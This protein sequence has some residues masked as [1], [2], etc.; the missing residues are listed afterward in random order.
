MEQGI[1]IAERMERNDIPYPKPLER[2]G[3]SGI[4]LISDGEL[5]KI[6]ASSVV[7]KRLRDLQMGNGRYLEI[8]YYKPIRVGY[9]FNI[10]TKLH[11]LFK[12]KQ[13]IGEWFDLD[14]NDIDSIIDI[15]ESGDLI[16]T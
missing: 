11:K 4:Y 6:G 1:E 15:L 13:C 12:H 14:N 10:E 9:V 5:V 16:P 3:M 2:D 8:I 7:T